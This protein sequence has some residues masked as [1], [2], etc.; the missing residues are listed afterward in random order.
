MDL[1]KITDKKYKLFLKEPKKFPPNKGIV[2][3][4]FN[5]VL[6]YCLELKEIQGRGKVKL[7]P[8]A[9]FT[10]TSSKWVLIETKPAVEYELL[11][12]TKG[13]T[14]NLPTNLRAFEGSL[15]NIITLLNEI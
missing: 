2:S 3:G 6:N 1:L 12:L 7:I 13:K 14:I 9:S 11:W 15:K 4:D 5:T 8:Y 10:Q